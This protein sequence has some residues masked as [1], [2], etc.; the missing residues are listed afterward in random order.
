[1]A[2]K[3]AKG[4]ADLHD[5]KYPSRDR[6]PTVKAREG[7]DVEQDA[8]KEVASRSKIP[9]KYG[10]GTQSKPRSSRQTPPFGPSM[11]APDV[12][13]NHNP[14]QLNERQRLL[15]SDVASLSNADERDRPLPSPSKRPGS[16]SK[17]SRNTASPTKNKRDRTR[18]R[19]K[20]DKSLTM[21]DLGS[22]SPSIRIENI[23]DLLASSQCREGLPPLVDSLRMQLQKATG[24]VPQILQVSSLRRE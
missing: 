11:M 17:V 2:D 1:M 20:N 15:P 22:C 5:R 9:T 18:E 23:R 10:Q 4:Q 21:Q 13:L 19:P 16:P 8:Q 3:S 6:K 24:F 7:R 12:D 14:S